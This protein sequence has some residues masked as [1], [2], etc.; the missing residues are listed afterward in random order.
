MA[1]HN[2]HSLDWL[3][4]YLTIELDMNSPLLEA[5]ALYWHWF[6]NALAQYH[7]NPHSFDWNQDSLVLLH[8]VQCDGNAIQHIS[9][10]THE[11]CRAAITQNPDAIQYMSR[12][13]QARFPDLGLTVA[14]TKGSCLHVLKYQTADMCLAAM[15]TH[16]GRLQDVNMADLA[17]CNELGRYPEIC[18]AAVKENGLSLVQVPK[19]LRGLQDRRA[20]D[21][22]TAVWTQYP[23]ICL[24]AVTQTGAALKY[25]EA[26]IQEARPDIV[27][28]ALRQ[29]K[30][31]AQPWVKFRNREITAVIMESQPH[32]TVPG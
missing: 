7:R 14:Q 31:A 26:H 5:L 19:I 24:A 9:E 10:H 3:N 8:I 4:S 2:V 6:H 18:L 32:R 11:M 25:V 28:A 13:T 29:N 1:S 17:R 12:V 30:Q 27:L 15:R 16:G 21:P 23:E 20:V 22:M